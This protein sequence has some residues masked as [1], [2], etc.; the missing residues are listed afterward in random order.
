LVDFSLKIEQTMC[1]LGRP[2]TTLFILKKE[3]VS[4]VLRKCH[5]PYAYLQ[6][7]YKTG[8]NTFQPKEKERLPSVA[9]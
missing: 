3:Q 1:P 6:Q 7:A 5:G 4:Q 9:T 8:E 2:C